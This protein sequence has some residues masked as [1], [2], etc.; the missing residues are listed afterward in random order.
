[1]KAILAASLFL[2][3]IERL[4]RTYEQRIRCDR[5]GRK[6][7]DAGARA[8]MYLIT[9]DHIGRSQG[10]DHLVCKGSSQCRISHV[11]LQYREFITAQAGN[12][13]SLARRAFESLCD[14]LQ[15]LIPSRMAAGIVYVLEAIQIQEQH[16]KGIR[17][18]LR[19]GERLPQ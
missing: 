14:G 10:A 19:R 16:R 17:A 3:T 15:E 13:V 7:R 9:V 6:Y 1:M 11:R 5:I 2:G 8:D 18:A 12:Q 4:I